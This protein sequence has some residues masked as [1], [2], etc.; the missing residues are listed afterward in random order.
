M[1]FTIFID[2][3]L[4]RAVKIYK[5]IVSSSNKGTYENK[6]QYIHDNRYNFHGIVGVYDSLFGV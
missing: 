4:T 1:L 3:N 5:I 2:G 6:K